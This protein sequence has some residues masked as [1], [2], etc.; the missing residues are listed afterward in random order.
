MSDKITKTLDTIL[1]MF[2]SGDI[3]QAVSR[4]MFPVMDV[5]TSNWSLA[6]RILA[7]RSDTS[8]G[9]TYKQWQ[10]VGRQ[11]KKGTSS[12]QIFAPRKITFTDKETEEKITILKGFLAVNRHRVEDTEGANLPENQRLE[13]PKFPL[14]KV[15]KKWGIDVGTLA[16]NPHCAGYYQH[17]TD[18]K[19][20]FAEGSVPSNSRKIRLASPDEAVFFHE[21]AHAAHGEIINLRGGQH[22]NQEIVAELSAA[23]LCQLIGTQPSNIGEHHRY[24]ARYAREAK[25]AQTTACM[26]VLADVEKVIN[27]I[28]ETGEKTCN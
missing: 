1:Q 13:L 5:P 16:S 26:K 18:A 8:D 4:T 24:I 20:A 14:L 23:A 22:W 27:L 19:N 28:L 7:M 17:Q 10:A 9:R 12:F 21:L 6:N 11:V 3:P 2:E 15:A 25:L